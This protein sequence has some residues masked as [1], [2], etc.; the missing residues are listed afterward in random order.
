MSD[1]CFNK[2]DLGSQVLLRLSKADR[3]NS[4]MADAIRPYVG[5]N[6]L[7]I[8][9]GIGNLTKKLIPRE[10]YLCTDINPFHL[11]ITKKLTKNRPYLKVSY[12]DLTDLSGFDQNKEKFDTVVCINVIEHLDDDEK[13]VNNIA[14]LLEK[15]GRAVILVPRGQK[16]FGTLDEL[17]GH[18]R[19]Y[20][21]QM[22]VDLAKKSGLTVEKIL[23]Y[24]R[25]ST[26]FWVINGQILKKKN[27]GRAQI[28][29]M[30]LLTPVFRRIDRFVP[31]PSLSY[32][33]VFKKPG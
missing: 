16:I 9:S 30:D 11:E 4:W 31:S 33:A 7:E 25:V 8:G 22:L 1:D 27:F 18:K 15:K 2:N 28:F 5:E 32:L 12:L 29:I 13:A 24:N 6:V 21:K 14:R 20:S 19:R 17:V 3:F 10:H 26:I 23:P